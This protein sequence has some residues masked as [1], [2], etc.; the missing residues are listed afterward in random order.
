MNYLGGFWLWLDYVEWLLRAAH[1]GYQPM[2][3]GVF[4]L[5][6][7]LWTATQEQ[8][9]WRRPCSISLPYSHMPLWALVWPSM[10]QEIQPYVTNEVDDCRMVRIHRE[11]SGLLLLKSL[12][13]SSLDHIT[14]EWYGTNRDDWV[15]WVNGTASAE[16]TQTKY[17]AMSLV[18]DNSE[19]TERGSCLKISS[20]YFSTK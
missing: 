11:W 2:V 6:V 15:V 3:C 12:I 20:S 10:L 13:S 5:R 18:T 17:L 4:H 14:A 7:H 1:H 19:R 8:R 16:C 9:D